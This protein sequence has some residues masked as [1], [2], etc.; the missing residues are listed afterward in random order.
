MNENSKVLV[1]SSIPIKSR[2]AEDHG[3]AGR[4]IKVFFQKSWT[5]LKI[6]GVRR[7]ARSKFYLEDPLK[8]GATV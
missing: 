1:L 2:Q 7:G 4:G 6:L 3:G 8:L 5:R